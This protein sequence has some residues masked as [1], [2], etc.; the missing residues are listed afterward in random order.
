ME[1]F[2]AIHALGVEHCDVR[3]E[4]VLVD[5]EGDGDWVIDF[6]FYTVMEDGDPQKKATNEKS[7]VVQMLTEMKMKK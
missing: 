6:E 5:N 2:D 7:V 3:P 1:A 4:N